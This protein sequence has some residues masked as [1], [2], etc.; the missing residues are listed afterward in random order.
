M[1]LPS[2]E[3]IAG[4]PHERR[5]RFESIELS[6]SANVRLDSSRSRRSNSWTVSG[7]SQSSKAE[8][9]KSSQF[10]FAGLR[11]ESSWIVERW[12]GILDIGS[13]A[14]MILS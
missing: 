11:R 12:A 3:G 2:S 10:L 1:L 7:G 6:I 13:T 8:M 4:R 14:L 9:R 5:D